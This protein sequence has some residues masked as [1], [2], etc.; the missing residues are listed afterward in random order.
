[1]Y[2]Y[3]NLDLIHYKCELWRYADTINELQYTFYC[4]NFTIGT[5]A[6]VCRCL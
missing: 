4:V 2:Y 3:C 6:C 1:M 5:S